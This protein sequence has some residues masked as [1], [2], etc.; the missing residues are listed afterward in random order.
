MNTMPS[1]DFDTNPPVP[2][3]EYE[4]AVTSVNMG[5]EFIFELTHAFLRA[6][7]KGDLDLLVVGAGGGAEIERF[8]PGNLDW[9]VTGVDPSREMLDL[10][11]L[12]A[13]RLG[14]ADR[15][16]LIQGSVDDL[17]GD[18]RFDAATCLFVLH[19][20]P[21]DAKLALLRG[22]SQHI[23]PGA[24]ALSVSGCRVDELTLGDMRDDL[25]GT[26]QQYAEL[27]GMPAEQM[28]AIIDDIVARQA[29]ATTEERYRQLMHEAGFTQVVTV[30]SIMHDAACAW[31]AR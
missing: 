7:G 1:T 9:R 31:M 4:H 26:W 23:H 14:V 22:I 29:Q 3:M 11:R 27:R 12:K 24:P 30:L 10:A 17:P 13:E 15:V 2:V 19:F 25:L 21:D 8:L 18:R 20:L 5:Y 16:T 6:L 28:R